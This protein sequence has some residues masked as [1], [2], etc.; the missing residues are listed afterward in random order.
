MKRTALRRRT[1]IHRGT[2]LK[3]S[4]IARKSAKQRRRDRELEKSRKV[5]M[6]RSHGKCE[7]PTCGRDGVH[8]HHRRLRSQGGSNLPGNLLLLCLEH[9]SLIHR[10]PAWAAA[11]GL[12]ETTKEP[13][14]DQV[15]AGWAQTNFDAT[16]FCEAVATKAVGRRTTDIT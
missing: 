12:I 5:V 11:A 9:H 6:Q 1:A 3:R 7:V 10:N 4:P 15:A 13:D 16:A 2:P 14:P 8:L